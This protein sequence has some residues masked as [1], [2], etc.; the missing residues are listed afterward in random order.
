M[1]WNRVKASSLYRTY[2]S[3]PYN[4]DTEQQQIQNVLLRD[5]IREL[6]WKHE[7]PPM[8]EEEALL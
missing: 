3:I 2:F 8:L 6:I 1:G 5:K 4:F 7:V